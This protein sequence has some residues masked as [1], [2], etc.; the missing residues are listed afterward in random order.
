MPYYGTID[1]TPLWLMLLHETWRWTGDAA[2]VRELLP[3][4]ERAL[5][6]IDRYGDIDG[7]GF[8]EY[9]ETSPDG[10]VNQGWKDS[11]DGVPFP[12]GTL[13][14][15]RSRS[16]KCR[17][18]SSTPSAA[19]PRS[20]RRSASRR[21]RER[22]RS[23]ASALRERIDD[24]SGSRSWAPSRWRSTGTSARCHGHDERGT[25]LWSRVPDAT[26]AARSAPRCS[27]P[28]CSAAGAFA[29]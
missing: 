16:S 19:W 7:D 29:L 24:A 9:A 12:D 18:T 13:P 5:D 14:R 6:W 26:R 21:A 27:R 8:V 22:L 4:A 23:E 2:L 15:R 10:L 28:T 1:A 17:A 11:W 25:L 20:T 3:N